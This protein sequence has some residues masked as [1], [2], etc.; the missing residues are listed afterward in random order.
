MLN[1]LLTGLFLFT[2]VP[3]SPCPGCDSTVARAVVLC[4][5]RHLAPRNLQESARLLDQVLTT[6]PSH[7]KALYERSRVYYFQAKGVETK[8]EKLKLYQQGMDC[9]KKAIASDPR[10]ADAHFWY[11]V[12]L[13]SSAKTSGSWSAL[14][15]VGEMKKEIGEVFKD[16]PGSTGALDVEAN[17]YY[18][19][20]G[21]W[22]GDLNKS[23]KDLKK[24]V[25]EDSNFTRLYVDLAKV[26]IK[27]KNY[28]KARECLTKTLTIQNPSYPADDFL[29]DHPTALKLLRQLEAQRR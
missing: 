24:A 14:N 5:T 26:Y 10:A 16:D 2:A 17:L 18:E 19:L 21:L 20:P 23:L 9:G 13:G 6:D 22:G 8:K 12:N 27:E 7:V 25:Q 11:L 29:D 3:Q 4:D 15:A 1:F 28:G